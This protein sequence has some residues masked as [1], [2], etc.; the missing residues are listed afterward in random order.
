M[1]EQISTDGNH[2][3]LAEMM[4]TGVRIACGGAV[5]GGDFKL[6]NRALKEMREASEVGSSGILLGATF[7][8]VVT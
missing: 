3:L 5:T 2:C 1:A 4:I 6:M 7:E 8:L